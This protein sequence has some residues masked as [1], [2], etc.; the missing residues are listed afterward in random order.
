MITQYFSEFIFYSF[1]GWVWESIYCTAK[2]K[3]W[4]DRGFL[5]GPVCPIYGCC[6]VIFS[7]ITK[8]F[9]VINSKDF[10]IWGLFIMGVVGSAVIEFATSY[11]LEKRFHARWWDYSDIIFNI[12]GRICLP[13]SIAFG[14]AGIFILRY[15]LPAIEG[16]RLYIHPEI[17]AFASIIMAALFGA[18]LAL[19]EASLSSLLNNVREMH[20]E[21]NQ[22]AQGN[23]EKLA[24]QPKMIEGKITAGI[25]SIEDNFLK[26]RKDLTDLYAKKLTVNQKRVLGSIRVFTQD[27]DKP[28]DNIPTRSLIWQEL[29]DSASKVKKKVK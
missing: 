27:K 2:E 28:A 19:T 25:Q 13:V 8:L 6:V 20:E 9:P 1:L 21:L 5:F 18:D 17:Y 26:K 11:V 29:K 16:L 14:L 12:Q 10:P 23:Y 3:K 24:A 7:F 15:A 4:A 22:K